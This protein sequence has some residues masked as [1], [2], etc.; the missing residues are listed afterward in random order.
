[1]QASRVLP[2]YACA[3][4]PKSGTIWEAKAPDIGLAIGIEAPLLYLHTQCINV[5]VA[6]DRHFVRGAFYLDENGPW[7]LAQYHFGLCTLL[8]ALLL[9]WRQQPSFDLPSCIF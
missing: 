2:Q 6:H 9:F 3:V 5:F 8:Q 7:S 4:P 1:M